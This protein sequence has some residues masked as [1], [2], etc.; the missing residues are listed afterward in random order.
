MGWEGCQGGTRQ[1]SPSLTLAALVIP[2][3]HVPT[4]NGTA[5]FAA[6][7]KVYE[8]NTDLP[9]L[10]VNLPAFFYLKRGILK[11]IISYYKMRIRAGEKRSIPS[12]HTEKVPVSSNYQPDNMQ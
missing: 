3:S 1:K 10:L 12:D 8:I 11:R 5:A 7:R 6:K 2:R 4:G 9:G